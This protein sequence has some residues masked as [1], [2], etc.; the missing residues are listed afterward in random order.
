MAKLIIISYITL[1]YTFKKNWGV[2]D[3]S[4]IG[5]LIGRIKVKS[6]CDYLYLCDELVTFA[7]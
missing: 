5:G 4:R 6:I 2:R 3:V 7:K 1:S